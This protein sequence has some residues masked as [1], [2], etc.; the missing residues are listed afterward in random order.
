MGIQEDHR[1]L[2][3]SCRQ[4]SA[5]VLPKL[6]DGMFEKLDD[7]LY[8]MADKAESNQ[9][10]CSFFDAMRDVRKDRE[11]IS[12]DFGRQVLDGYD[13]FW[14]SGRPGSPGKG[15]NSSDEA[16]GFSLME[17]DALEEGLA[18][19]NIITRGENR[20]YRALYELNQRFAH[21][22][23]FSDLDV[24]DNPLAPA[25]LA[26]AFQDQTKPMALGVQVKLVIYKQFQREV[27]DSLETFYKEINSALVQGGVL[28]KMDKR[29]N[30][31]ETRPA[32]ESRTSGGDPTQQAYTDSESF[33]EDDSQLQAEIF[34][35]LKQLLGRRR[36]SVAM[37]NTQ[38]YPTL[39][40]AEVVK[41]LSVLQQTGGSYSSDPTPS[42][43]ESLDVR[44]NLIRVMDIGQGQVS[45]ANINRNDEDTIDVIAM[46]FEFILEDRNLPDAMKALL[47]RLQ[48]PMLKAAILDKT[49]F[50]R[51]NHPARRLLNAM[52]QAAVGWSGDSGRD[53]SGLYNK[54]SA[55]VDR[56]LTGFDNNVEIFSELNDDFAAYIESE[57]KGSQRTEHRVTQIIQGKEQLKAA[58]HRVF[59]EINNRMFGR[60]GIPK[61]V[62]K[63]IKEGWRDVLQLIYLRKGEESDE[64]QRALG[65]L[66]KLL[67]SVTPKPERAEKQA[68]LAE[69]PLL[70]KGLRAGLNEISF[71]QHKMAKLFKD[72]QACHLC[73]LKGVDP[74]AAMGGGA[75]DQIDNAQQNEDSNF[76]G[77]KSRAASGSVVRDEYFDLAES[78]SIG[79]WLEVKESNGMTFRAKLSWRSIV[80]DTCLF[81]NRKGQKVVEI[82]IADFASWLRTGKAWQLEEPDVPLMDRALTAMMD[83]LKKT[84]KEDSSVT[85]ELS[86]AEST[87][88]QP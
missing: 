16:D 51:K 73:C 23:G 66:D 25:A 57:N 9:H 19:T 77:Q 68:L 1:R 49:F 55:I 40:T 11:R 63:L 86:E 58:R 3:D 26:N 59:E 82:P 2:L 32:P 62:N 71:D 33:D 15:G 13:R 27:I 41:A 7:A 69:T 24:R 65:L 79:T 74:V 43:N 20:Y 70:L 6:L 8:A 34:G 22:A 81:V 38:T 78:I 76:N 44:A 31:S 35:T 10:Q 83:V 75:E 48:I 45:E 67:W 12:V 64:W 47:S 29:V 72:L 39:D 61:P 17:N 28:V 54:M 21:L 52:A 42:G 88:T 80:S 87:P 36:G 46:L 85:G 18:I 56:V 5:K 14:N 4:I 53:G 60:E 37:A 30:R 84:E 50:N